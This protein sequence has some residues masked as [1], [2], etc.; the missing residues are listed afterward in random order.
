M[1]DDILHQI[2]TRCNDL[3]ITFSDT[4]YKEA[5]TAIEDLCIV[6]ANLPVS[7]F[8]MRLPNQSTSDLMNTEMN[9]ELQYNTVEMTAIVTRN[10]SLLGLPDLWV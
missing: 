10:V 5:L 9:S 2:R 3:T 6:T 4:I 1:T 7:H 8:S